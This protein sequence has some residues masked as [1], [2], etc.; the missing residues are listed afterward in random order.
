MSVTI[1]LAER[2]FP[3]LGPRTVAR[4][5]PLHAEA[6]RFASGIAALR[7]C[8]PRADVIVLPFM[9]QQIWRAVFD[10]RDLTMASMFDEPVVT[11]QYLETYGAFFIH[12]GLTRIGPAS[13]DDPH[14]LHGELPL[15]RFEDCTLGI[16]EA[17]GV[18]NIEGRYRHRRA[19]GVN[20]EAK[21]TITLDVSETVLGVGL[22]VVNR[23]PAAPLELMYLGHAN[24]RPVDGG[25][26]IY[27]ARYTPEDVAVRRS[28]PPHIRPGPGLAE[29]LADLARNPARHHILSPDLPF[30]PEVVFTIRALADSN[31]WSHALHLHPDGAADFISH[32]ARSLPLAMRWICR[33]GDQQGL[34]M[35]MPATA[36]VE[37]YVA[38][39]AA[40]RIV[41]VSPGGTWSARMKMGALDPAAARALEAHI[42]RIGGRG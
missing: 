20:Y 28:I 36:G 11:D 9:G 32:D 17:G 30:D 3:D 31:G 4:C 40:G 16:D 14:P 18:I 33:T 13:A 21:A 12:C 15:A 41:T 39:A 8:T 27:A 34:G 26:L 5:G 1:P 42:E 23:R 29:F 35:A 2:D 38:E 7:L 10:G 37:G 22:D 6:F 19:F 25:R 24:F